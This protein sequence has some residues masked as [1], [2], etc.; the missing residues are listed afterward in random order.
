MSIMDSGLP[1][2]LTI[3]GPSRE[4]VLEMPAIVNTAVAL[5]GHVLEQE[6][7]EALVVAQLSANPEG[8]RNLA[9]KAKA[10]LAHAGVERRHVVRPPEWYLAQ[11]S[12]TA[13]NQ[14]YCEEMIRLCESAAGEAL[15]GAG[16][17]PGEVGMI[18]TTSCT[19][20]MIPSVDAYLVNRMGFSPNVCR[21][22]LT[23]LGCAAGAVALGRA[24]DYLRAWPD[25][26]VLV[27]SAELASLT[28]QVGDI[29]MANIVS[30]ALFGDGV[31]AT[32][33]VGDRFHK[34]PQVHSGPQRGASS[35]AEAGA[36]AAHH[37]TDNGPGNVP[38]NGAG[39]G[40]G[41][42]ANGARALPA[43]IVATQSTLFPDTEDMMGFDLT[44]GGLKIFLRAKVPRFLRGEVPKVLLGFLAGH[45]LTPEHI[46]HY[47]LHP[48]GPKVLGGISEQLGLQP[49]QTALSWRVLRDYGNLSSATVLFLLH[50]FERQASPNPGEWG[51]LMA[52]GPG[53]AME[54]VLLQW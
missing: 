31:A 23:E 11:R 27:I 9:A 33:L 6:A 35:P 24:A 3:P 14:V 49:E 1:R 18:I 13:R 25:Q 16:L 50:H 26:A 17:V 30:V 38:G 28:A 37:D 4:S 39:N 21:L 19:G 12:L 51:L 29:S 10:I 40:S 54:L 47:L 15:A 2:T 8:G 43:R 44:D 46:T 45:G 36:G 41:N 34:G 20:V 53:F 32:V 7:L 42:G 52:V 5:P 48:G 22:P